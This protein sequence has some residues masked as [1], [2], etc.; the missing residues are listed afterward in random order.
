MD[1][2]LRE[3]QIYKFIVDYQKQNGVTPST[4]TIAEHL[5]LSMAITRYSLEQLRACGVVDWLLYRPNTLW[6]IAWFE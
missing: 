6:V 5:G 2:I 3:C 1:S 4:R